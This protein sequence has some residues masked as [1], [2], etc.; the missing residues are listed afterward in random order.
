MLGRTVAELEATLSTNEWAE[1]LALYSLEGWGET[2][3]D[4][5][6]GQIA[7]TIANC[8]R[9]RGTKPF[10]AGDFF[11]SL[12]SDDPAPPAPAPAG[13]AGCPSPAFLAVLDLLQRV[14]PPE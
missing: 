3:A 4:L 13:E 5:R 2:Q 8:N 11:R 14:A 6:A 9:S 12:R 1:W 10:G 7:A